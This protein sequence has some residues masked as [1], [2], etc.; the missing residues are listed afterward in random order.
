ML[1]IV[2]TEDLQRAIAAYRDDNVG[3][4]EPCNV[5]QTIY[6]DCKNVKANDGKKSFGGSAILPQEVES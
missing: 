5:C 4:K 1:Q 2:N 6:L 3:F